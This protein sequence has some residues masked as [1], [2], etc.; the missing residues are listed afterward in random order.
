MQ[1]AARLPVVELVKQDLDV[2]VR[3]INGV[4]DAVQDVAGNE[5]LVGRLAAAVHLDGVLTA[6]CQPAVPGRV[7]LWL[8]VLLNSLFLQFGP[9]ME[10]QR[11]KGP[12]LHRP[13]AQYR[14][15]QRR[16]LGD[17]EDVGSDFEVRNVALRA[18]FDANEVR[19]FG[20]LRRHGVTRIFINRVF[21][22]EFEDD[23]VKFWAEVGTHRTAI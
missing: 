15:G 21:L 17:N 23:F 11:L 20:F 5:R 2:R 8:E 6:W 9:L 3:R 12:V 18:A 7:G 1:I 4:F 13:L 10:A 14:I 16:R 22:D 19:I